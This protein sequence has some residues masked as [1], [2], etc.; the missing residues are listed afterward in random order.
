MSFRDSQATFQ[1]HLIDLSNKYYNVVEATD[2]LISDKTFDELVEEYEATFKTT[3]DYIGA[4]G[5]SRHYQK[6]KLPVCMP[7]LNKAKTIQDLQRY[8]AQLKKHTDNEA[9]NPHKY[10]FTEKMDGISLLLTITP[11]KIIKAYTRGNGV[12]GS[13]VSHILKYIKLPS[14][15]QFSLLFS[16]FPSTAASK[17]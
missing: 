4:E 13:D 11:S 3:F 15:K 1:Q 7:S 16:I 12:V 9:T 6:V 14:F 2:E 5:T 8:D 17:L 10:L